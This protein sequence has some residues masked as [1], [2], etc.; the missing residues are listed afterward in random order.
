MFTIYSYAVFFS[1]LFSLLFIITCHMRSLDYKS[2]WTNCLYI[3]MHSGFLIYILFTDSNEEE[4]DQQHISFHVFHLHFLDWKQKAETYRF[5]ECR[6]HAH[7]KEYLLD[8]ANALFI[9]CGYKK[10]NIVQ[11]TCS[12]SG[13]LF[14]PVLLHCVTT[15]YFSPLCLSRGDL[16]KVNLRC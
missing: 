2:T 15:I 16:V 4:Q 14:W 1:F 6:G 8:W 7:Q 13:L 5:A 9:N 3:S 11:K 12:S 10:K